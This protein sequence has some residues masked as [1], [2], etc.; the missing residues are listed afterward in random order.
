MSRTVIITGAN[1]GIGKAATQ[2][3]ASEGDHVIMACRSIQRSRNIQ[4]ELISSTGNNNITLMQLDISSF[5]SIQQ[6]VQQFIEKFEKLDLLIHNAAYLKH[7]EPRYLLSEDNI[8]LSFATNVV[9]PYLLTQLLLP[10][11]GKAKQPAILHACTTNIKHFFD[12]K[13]QIEY[14][15]LRGEY[16]NQRPFNSYKLYGDSKMALFLL[17]IK[18]SD[19]LKGQKVRVNAL[20]INRVKLSPETIANLSSRYRMLARLQNPTSQPTSS[21]AKLYYDICTSANYSDITGSLINHRGIV[22]KAATS[23]KPHPFQLV[24]YLTSD[25][26][27]PAYATNHTY[28]NQVWVFCEQATDNILSRQI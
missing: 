22:M 14:D 21:M 19:Q 1:S 11:L 7:G 20:Q 24:R 10:Q 5:A 2:K 25:Q 12:P 6:F 8:E 26:Y 18:L 16:A 3:F 15:N 4:Q 9:G 28:L 13:R 23:E 17:T 27:Y